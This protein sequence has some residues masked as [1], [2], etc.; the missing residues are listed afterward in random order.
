MRCTLVDIR[1]VANRRSL[2]QRLS[3]SAR[4]CVDKYQHVLSSFE[5]IHQSRLTT[6]KNFGSQSSRGSILIRRLFFSNAGS[7]SISRGSRSSS[8]F[9]NSVCLATGNRG[10][11]N[12]RVAPQS[13]IV[14]RANMRR[15]HRKPIRGR[16]ASSISGQPK[17]PI[18]APAKIDPPASARCLSNHSDS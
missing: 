18:P 8:S 17:P 11:R 15:V 13:T 12:G 9:A 3:R 5:R 4:G 10:L 14:I 2:E 1:A 7:R 6:A 16:S